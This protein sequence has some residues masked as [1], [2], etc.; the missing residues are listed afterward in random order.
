MFQYMPMSQQDE[1]KQALA[2]RTI[3]VH[4]L[5]DEQMKRVDRKKAIFVDSQEEIKIKDVIEIE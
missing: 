5:S 2:S 4:K 1:L 3:Q